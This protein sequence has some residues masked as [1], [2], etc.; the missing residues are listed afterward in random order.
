MRLLYFLLIVKILSGRGTRI[1]T[2]DLVVPND[3]RYRAALHPENKEYLP[4]A[5]AKIYFFYEITLHC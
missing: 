3:A 5:I 4:F 2:W 1:R